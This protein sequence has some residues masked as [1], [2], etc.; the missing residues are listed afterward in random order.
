MKYEVVIQDTAESGNFITDVTHCD[1]TN[2]LILTQDYC[3]MPV[4]TAL[5]TDPFDLI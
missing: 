3:D 1:G 2:A 4:I 5:R